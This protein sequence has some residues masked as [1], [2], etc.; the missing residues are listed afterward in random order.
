LLTNLLLVIL[1]VAYPSASNLKAEAQAYTSTFVDHDATV[2]YLK[3]ISNHPP[4]VE[5]RLIYP[6]FPNSGRNLVV[7][8]IDEEWQTVSDKAWLAHPRT[9][10]SGN[11]AIFDG[12]P[13]SIAAKIAEATVPMLD[14]NESLTHL[15]N[16]MEP[17]P[18]PNTEKFGFTPLKYNYL[19]R[20]RVCA[21]IYSSRGLI[22]YATPDSLSLKS[23]V[24]IS[25]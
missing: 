9:C 8:K 17:G 4:T 22:F 21:D 20:F 14:A 6:R 3:A 2:R 23:N 16:S 5:V 10:P 7:K 11:I 24:N 13:I 12:I 1:L 18:R 25:H 19:I 15:S